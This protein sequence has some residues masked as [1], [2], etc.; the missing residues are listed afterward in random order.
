MSDDLGYFAKYVFEQLELTGA[1]LRRWSQ[2]LEECGYKFEKNAQRQRIY[3]TKDLELLHQLKSLVV[4]KGQPVEVAA[5]I[6]IDSGGK[7][8]QAP[9]D[10]VSNT[11]TPSAQAQT[12]EDADNKLDQILEYVKRQD[13]KL[14]QQDE[15]NKL[16][17]SKLEEQQRYITESLEKRDRALVESLR[18][19]QETQKQ[20]AAAEEIKEEPKGFFARLF[21][22]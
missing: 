1:T 19:A 10:H 3:Y 16:L 8:D 22:K 17:V 6:V 11:Y 14:S 20:I 2:T 21:G 12:S 18:Q 13:E 4:E 5:K 9:S 15:F 7:R